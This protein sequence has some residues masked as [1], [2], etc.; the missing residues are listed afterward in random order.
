MR[1]QA[2][3]L[4]YITEVWSEPHGAE[5]ELLHELHL[6]VA[7]SPKKTHAHPA[8]DPQSQPQAYPL[9]LAHALRPHTRHFGQPRRDAVMAKPLVT[10]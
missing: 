3:R 8:L 10:R 4:F 9:T 5:D 6:Q 1:Q 2:S 7:L